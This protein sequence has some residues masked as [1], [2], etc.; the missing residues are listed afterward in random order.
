MEGMKSRGRKCSERFG[1]K[2]QDQYEATTTESFEPHDCDSTQNLEE[3]LK[4]G[5]DQVWEQAWRERVSSGEQEARMR[6]Q[7]G[8]EDECVRTT[9]K[10]LVLIPSFALR[11]YLERR[12][13]E[14]GVAYT[15]SDWK[16]E[17]KRKLQEKTDKQA[18]E[19]KSLRDEMRLLQGKFK[20]QAEE[21]VWKTGASLFAI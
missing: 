14:E 21:L 6:C 19:L 15:A 10:G 3:A 9:L 12:C 8:A 13:E 1:D 7:E 4:R 17:D 18:A 2:Q 11:Q 5:F 20:R 16:D